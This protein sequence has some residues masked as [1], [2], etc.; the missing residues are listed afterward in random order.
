MK[1]FLV[2]ILAI[3]Y[4]TTSVGATVQLHY[5]MSDLVGWEFSGKTSLSLCTSCGMKKQAQKGC[6]HN[7][8]KTLKI[9]KDQKNVETFFN[10]I[11]TPVAIIN[12]NYSFYNLHYRPGITNEQL[13]SHAP[14]Y[15]LTVPVYLYNCVFRI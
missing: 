3:I 6:C 14:P 1:K 5:C 11:K 8:K 7:E 2:S 12:T 10:L 4:F 9:E 15:N 13:W